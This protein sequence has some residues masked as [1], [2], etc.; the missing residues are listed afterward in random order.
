MINIEVISRKQNILNKYLFAQDKLCSREFLLFFHE[1]LFSY[2]LYYLP[3]SLKDD[4]LASNKKKKKRA[5]SI[6][7]FF[8]LEFYSEQR[9]FQ[10]K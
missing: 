7:V 1:G 4:Q 6:Y 8:H 10:N 2:Y 3:I 5:S 9:R